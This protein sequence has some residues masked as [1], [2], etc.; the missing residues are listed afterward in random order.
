[1]AQYAVIGLGRFGE[2]IARS[3]EAMGHEV[4][5]IDKSEQKVQEIADYVTAAVRAD[6]KN[7]EFLRSVDIASFDAVIVA[8]TQNIEANIL[9]TML[10]KDLGA[11]YIVAKAQSK[12]HGEVLEK[13]GV[14]K[15]IYPE[16]D[17]GERVARA[18][19]SAHNILDYIELSPEHSIVEFNTPEAFTGK[20]LKE[21]DLRAKCNI[22]VLAAKRGN[23]IIVAPGG[24]FV[25]EKNDILVAIGPHEA[26][27]N[28]NRK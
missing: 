15:I 10:L 23:E 28:I 20:S 18:L 12:L 8:M 24:E 13:I 16:W 14:D 25:I 3:L 27:K 21:L 1:M 17:M 9:V 26:L 19:T 22:S 2:S 6:A 5:A 11:K 7:E 4:L